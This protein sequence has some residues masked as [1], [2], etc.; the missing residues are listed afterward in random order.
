MEIRIPT[1]G[2][3]IHEAL[4]VAWR[5]ADGA[6]VRQGEVLCDLETDKVNVELPAEI[7]GTVQIAVPAGQTLPVGAIIGAIVPGEVA[8]AEP[9][10]SARPVRQS[11]RC[12]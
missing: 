8:A 3:S 11:A 4:L 2:E 10:A 9:A 1:V 6:P 7:S 5:V 12:R